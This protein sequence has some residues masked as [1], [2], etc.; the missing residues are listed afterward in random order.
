V[1]T[2]DQV[3]SALATVND[4]EI[5][6]PITE[7]DMVREVRVEGGTVSLGIT[8]TV[9]GCPLKDKITNDVTAAVKALGGVDRVDI[10][11]GS[12]TEQQRGALTERLRGGA[13]R[14]PG[15]QPVIPFAQ[16]DSD[17]KVIA[18]ASGKGGVG[19]SSI[20][21]NL[22]VALA[23]DGYDVGVLDADVWGYS[24]PRMMGVQGRPVAFNGMVM[25]LQGHGVK[26]ISIGFF[27]DTERPVIWRGPMLHR[28]LQQFLADVHWGDLD[29]L[30][31]DLPPGTGDIAISLAQMLPNADMLVVTTPQQAAQRVALRA[32]QMTAQAGMKVAGVIENMATFI[33]PDTGTEY[34]IFGEG[35]GELLAQ[36]LDTELLGSIPIDERLRAGSDT[37]MPL[38]IADP[39]AV[40]SHRLVEIARKIGKGKG[41]GSLVGK[42]LPL[43]F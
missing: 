20:T 36:E 2:I 3:R 37:G 11:F 25:P 35:G 28:A 24:I 14:A 9:P 12:M 21:T 27:V 29:F 26:V 10:V 17:T 18:I 43:H 4:P 6:K 33:A 5:G 16:V 38:V 40:A 19:K 22:A 31:C 42:P 15:G 1:P 41:R 39:D 23:A 30:L 8:L 7:L 13:Q 34:R 32:G